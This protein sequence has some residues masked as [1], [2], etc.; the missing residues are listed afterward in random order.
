MLPGGPA[1]AWMLAG[2]PKMQ[3][4]AFPFVDRPVNLW[5]TGPGGAA[6]RSLV[7]ATATSK[8][9]QAKTRTPPPASGRMAAFVIWATNDP[10]GVLTSR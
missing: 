3:G 9:S 7:S 5:L 1:I 2:L 10:T 8:C 6:G 4:A